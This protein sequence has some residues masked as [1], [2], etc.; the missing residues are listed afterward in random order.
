MSV[1][2]GCTISDG[3]AYCAIDWY[4]SDVVVNEMFGEFNVNLFSRI[5]ACALAVL[6]GI[7]VI[8]AGYR[9][10]AERHV[11]LIQDSTL[12]KCQRDSVYW[13]LSLISLAALT[14]LL[15]ALTKN[16]P[17]WI[18]DDWNSTVKWCVKTNN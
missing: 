7:K 16:N 8:E 10:Y 11:V 2:S 4:V 15:L 18:L 6:G 9:L 5:F 3:Q 12:K 13:N 14:L 17:S 1:V